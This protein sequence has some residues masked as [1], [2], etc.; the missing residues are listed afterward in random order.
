MRL[1][2]SI[3]FPI[4]IA[5]GLLPSVDAF[6]AEGVDARSVFHAGTVE[7]AAAYN[8]GAIDRIVALYAD[9]AVV[10]PPD[11]PAALGPAALRSFLAKDIAASRAAGVTLALSGDD[12]VVTS[13]D[14]GWHRG[15]FNAVGKDGATVV[16]GKYLEIWQRQ[17]GQWRI[18]RDIWNNDAPAAAP[19]SASQQP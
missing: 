7:W 11:A 1:P 13:G 19:P 2:A 10:M 5:I 4:A 16:T 9:D 8:A 3:A 15:T 18:V 17:H 14:I 12:D 6:A